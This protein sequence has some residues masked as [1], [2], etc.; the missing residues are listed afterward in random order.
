M[1]WRWYCSQ[2]RGLLGRGEAS[3]AEGPPKGAQKAHQ[4]PC[5]LPGGA[6]H[7]TTAPVTSLNELQV[8]AEVRTLCTRPSAPQRPPEELKTGMQEGERWNSRHRH[9]A[10]GRK[11]LPPLY[12]SC[13]ARAVVERQ[14]GLCR[15][16]AAPQV[17]LLP[18]VH[19]VHL[20]TSPGTAQPT[21]SQIP[22]RQ[23][24]EPRARL[25]GRSPAEYMCF[26]PRVLS[27]SRSE[28]E[29]QELM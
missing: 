22:E 18:T 26:F 5:L 29:P 19:Q 3:V 9:T 21:S 2:S 25:F 10:M 20:P 4:S 23:G 8:L 7:P 15:T 17:P 16:P 1:G 6:L 13:L 27:V 11:G 12:A 28:P 14:A 24:R